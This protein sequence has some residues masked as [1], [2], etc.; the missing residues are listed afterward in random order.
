MNE[1][2]C[3]SLYVAICKKQNCFRARLTPKPYRIKMQ[4]Y[5]VKYPSEDDDIEF[6][7]WLAAYERESQNFSVCKFVEQTGSSQSLT[8]IVRLHDEITGA[9][10]NRSLA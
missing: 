4:A 10:I 5:K 6:Q 8:D 9:Y 3:D 1:F 2:N 7:N